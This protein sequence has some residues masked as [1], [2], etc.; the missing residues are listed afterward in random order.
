MQLVIQQKLLQDKQMAEYLKQNSDWFK[1]LNR[2]P[3]NYTE[4]TSQMKEKYKTRTTDKVQ[5]F[6]DNVDMINSVLNVLK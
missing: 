5:S 6:I 2:D 3:E 4:F 1:Y